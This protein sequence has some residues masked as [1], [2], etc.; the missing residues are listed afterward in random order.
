MWPGH[1]VI[2]LRVPIDPSRPKRKNEHE[3]RSFE[4]SAVHHS[5]TMAN[6]CT[7]A[8]TRPSRKWSQPE[9]G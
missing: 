1:V 5:L 6:F 9:E 4:K 8:L 3:A 7:C 2:A